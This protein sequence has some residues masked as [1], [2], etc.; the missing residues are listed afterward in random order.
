M[1]E[2]DNRSTSSEIG[3]I[4]EEKQEYTDDVMEKHLP[5]VLAFSVEELRNE[6]R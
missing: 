2:D 1:N 6:E 4:A 3:I 5:K